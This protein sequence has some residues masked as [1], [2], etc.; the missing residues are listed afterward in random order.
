MSSRIEQIIE[1]IED[2]GRLAVTKGTVQARQGLHAVH[3]LQLLVHVHG[4]ELGLVKAG[5]KFVGND[6]HLIIIAIKGFAHIAAF[7]VGVHVVLGV[8]VAE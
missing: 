3:A 2:E 4:A 7:E 5:L 8:F 6:H 1:E